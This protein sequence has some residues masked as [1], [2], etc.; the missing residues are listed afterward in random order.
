MQQYASWDGVPQKFTL[1]PD[2]SMWHIAL[3]ADTTKCVDLIGSGSQLGNGTAMQINSCQ[4]GHASQQWTIS[5]D[6]MTGAFIF[7]NVQAGR[8][9]DEPNYNTAS[10]V[11]LDIWDCNNQTNQKFNI[12]AY[13]TTN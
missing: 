11:W 8:C 3:T 7:K 4:M 2:G 12:Q 1:I 10:G 13:S 9:L 5:A 6:A